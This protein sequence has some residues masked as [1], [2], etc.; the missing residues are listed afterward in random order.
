MGHW[1]LG[2][3]PPRKI[4][5]NPNSNPNSNPNANPNLNPNRGAIFLGGNWPDTES[6]TWLLLFKIS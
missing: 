4:A 6:V 3:F 2:Q 5:P 1:V